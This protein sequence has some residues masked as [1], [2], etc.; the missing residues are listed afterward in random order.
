MGHFDQEMQAQ[1]DIVERGDGDVAKRQTRLDKR[2]G[3]LGMLAVHKADV[4]MG[5]GLGEMVQEGGKEVGG[6]LGGGR[7]KR[8]RKRRSRRRRSDVPMGA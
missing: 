7:R 4:P 1:K 6:R 3:F 8:K 2:G 5:A